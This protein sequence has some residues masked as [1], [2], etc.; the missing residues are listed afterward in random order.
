MPDFD[1]RN[2]DVAEYHKDNL[3]FWLNKGV[4]G[5]RFDA[6]GVLF[7]NGPNDWEDQPET[8]ILLNELKTLIEGYGKR[9]LVCEAPSIPEDYARATSCGR[10]FAF[11]AQHGILDSVRS[12][13]FDNTFFDYLISADADRMP[14]FLSNHDSFAGARPWDQLI[15]NIADLKLAADT[16]LLTSSTPFTYYGEEVGMSGAATLSG[17]PS[18]RTPMSWTSDPVT[19]GFSAVTPFRELASNSTTQN[20]ELASLDN[21]SLLN[22]YQALFTLRNDYPILGRG[23]LFVQ[24]TSGGP[25]LVVSRRIGDE[26]AII[27]VNFS[28]QPQSTRAAAI[29]GASFVGI[30]GASDTRT[31]DALGGLDIDLPP[32]GSVV[33]YKAP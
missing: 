8:H 29:A 31:A 18:L 2:P 16:Y 4:D 6:V 21:A 12:G 32:R 23:D 11:N 9:Y 24:T 33:Y 26:M 7:E 30:Y 3:R 17:D 15:G 22:H 28:N 19:A 14:F 20:V 1:L 5:F 10:A 13:V 25:G 27:S